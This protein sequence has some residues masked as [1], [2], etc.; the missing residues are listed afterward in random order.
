MMSDR[1]TFVSDESL[2]RLMLLDIQY[3][4]KGPDNEIGFKQMLEELGFKQRFKTQ[5]DWQRV[6]KALKARQV[7][8]K[9]VESTLN[10]FK[11]EALSGIKRMEWYEDPPFWTRLVIGVTTPFVAR[12]A[13]ERN[14]REIYV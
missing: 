5:E 9:E 11:E 7:P 8:N 2:Q 10:A 3:W 14:R 6:W 4:E 1:S 12:W 13:L